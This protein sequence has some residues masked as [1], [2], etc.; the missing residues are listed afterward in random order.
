MRVDNRVL[1]A[2]MTELDGLESRGN[3]LVVGATNRRDLLDEGLLRPGRFGDQLLEIGRPG[4]KAALQIFARHLPGDIPYTGDPDPAV[5]RQDIIDSAVSRIYSPNA[6]NELL[7]LTM[8]DGKERGV[9]ASDLVSG[10]RIANIALAAK[11][12]A[13]CRE[14]ESGHGGIELG[15][16]LSVIDDEFES[17]ARV[18]TP[19]NCHRHIDDL[20]HDVDVV[21][22]QKVQR[23]VSRPHLY[24]SAA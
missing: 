18:L 4:R 14:L 3:I 2:F 15:S 10:A 5:A 6:G 22:V 24:V 16:V 23:K 12:R 8:R 17:A 13:V 20:P 1:E 7:L 11:E 21:R 19:A 9:K